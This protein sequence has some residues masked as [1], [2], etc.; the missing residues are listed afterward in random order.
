MAFPIHRKRR[1]RSTESLRALVRETHLEPSQFVLPLFVIEG[2]GIRKEIS[3]MPGHA[4]I[5]IDL[6][7]K[8][9]KEAES[10]GLGPV[11]LFGIP[12]H[13]DEI[14]SGAYAAD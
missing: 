11:I 8:E 1:L 5:S 6:A 14:A 13:K 7:V 9:C 12:D 10:L 2:K 4:Q 3:S